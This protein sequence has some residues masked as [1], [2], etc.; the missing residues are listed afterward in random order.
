MV[1]SF[2][3]ENE[4]FGHLV[5]FLLDLVLSY[6][7]WRAFLN[8]IICQ[9][10]LFFQNSLNSV[11]SLLGLFVVPWVSMRFVGFGNYFFNFAFSWGVNCTP[12]YVPSP[13]KFGSVIFGVNSI[14]RMYCNIFIL[15]EI[16]IIYDF[17]YYAWIAFKVLSRS[18]L[19]KIVW[20]GLS[21]SSLC[22]YKYYWLLLF[23][24]WIISLLV[25]CLYRLVYVP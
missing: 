12:Q 5:C 24:G 19:A 9:D 7:V 11:I 10:R 2:Q 21:F 16:H 15:I 4:L 17:P 8:K 1:K 23:D 13:D 18:I 22:V 3:V 25:Q 6:F 20:L 14:N